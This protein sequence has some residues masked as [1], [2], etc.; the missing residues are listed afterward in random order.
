MNAPTFALLLLATPFFVE[1]PKFE[2]SAPPLPFRDVPI[3]VSS[4]T[5]LDLDVSKD[6]TEVAF[7]LLGDIYV[8]PIGGGEARALTSGIA[9]DMQPTYSPDGRQLAFTSDRDGGD[10]LYV[11]DRDGQNVRAITK[12]TFRLVNEPA[13]EPSGSWL[14]GRK[15]FTARRSLGAGEMWLYHVSGSDGLQMTTKASEQK[16]T[17]EPVFSPDGRHLYF[18]FDATPGATFEYSKDSNAGIYAIQRLDRTTGETTT[19][20]SGPGGACRPTPSPDGKSLAYVRRERFETELWLFD[21]ESGSK[22][23]VCGALERDMQETWAIHGVYPR[24]AFTPDSRSIVYYARGGIQRVSLATGESAPIPFTVKDTRKVSSAVRSQHAVAP[25]MFKV[26]ALQSVTVAPDG[27]RVAFQALGRIFVREL[28]DGPVRRLTEQQGHFE[29]FPSFS[30]DSSSIV[31][32]TWHDDELGSIR[33]APASGGDGRTITSR[34]GTYVEP[35]FSPSGEHVVYRKTVGGGITSPLHGFEPGIY[36]VPAAGGEPR[37]IAK[38]GTNPSFGADPERV[39]LRVGRGSSDADRLALISLDLNGGDERTHASSENAVEF[40]VSPDGKWLG[41]VERYQAFVAPFPPLGRELKLSGTD[42]SLPVARVSKNAGEF[43][44][45][46]GDSTALHWALGPELFTRRLTDAFAFLAGQGATPPEPEERGLDISFEHLTARPNHTVVIENARI[47]TMKGDEVIENGLVLLE[48]NRIREVRAMKSSE[49]F[50]PGTVRIDGKGKTVIPG[51]IDV[52]AHGAQSENGLT[53]KRNWV[54]YAN[55]AFGVTTIHDPSHD[56]HAIFANAELQRAGLVVS[57]RTFSTGTILYG[58]YGTYKAEIETL[59]DARRH[60][61]RLAAIG[62]I[63]VKSYNQPRRDQRQKVLVAARELGMMVVPEGGSTLQHNLT[64]VIDGHT[65]IEHSLPVERVYDDV[66]QM[67][68]G[69]GVGYTPTLIVGYG[70]IWGENYW[71]DTTNVWE[72]ERLLAF[73]PR[74]VVDPRSRRRTRAPLEEYNHLRSAG[75]TKALVDAGE[76]VQLGAHGQIAGLGAHWELWMLEQGGLTPHQALR[77][78]TLDGARYL[79]LD[80]DLGSLEPGKLA[81]LLILDADPLA[82]LRNSE[83]ISL[84]IHNGE[85]YDAATMQA[86][87]GVR[88][89]FFHHRDGARANA[90]HSDCGCATGTTHAH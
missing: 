25:D 75:I 19:L 15:H 6:G 11:M 72:N 39:F 30:R 52:H 18:S 24:M 51:L 79:G 9:W 64:M 2:V 35:A 45:F 76:R 71:Y 69:S 73:V 13:W 29:F 34:P 7:S 43:L 57:P 50:A 54:N 83:R 28:P 77:A 1:E 59:D 42:K 4:G 46:S 31:Y 63:S 74:D 66:V 5:W 55:L 56:T 70:G 10:N 84:V 62:A 26:R 80:A 12:E 14:V 16:D 61:K 17:G 90:G 8:V 89:T 87:G 33:I 49:T 36:I 86:R 48:G 38:S 3:E 53:P 21:L 27:K 37:R 65:G 23:R 22:R 68:K 60:L 88:P 40:T 85:I 44:H 67:W 32:A 41:F 58:A 20:V 47:V 82:N 81:D 78:A